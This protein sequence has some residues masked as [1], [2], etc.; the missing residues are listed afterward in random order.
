MKNF[1]HFKYYFYIK[2]QFN[3]TIKHNDGI[4]WTD[5]ENGNKCTY[6]LLEWHVATRFYFHYIVP[7]GYDFLLF[8]S[9]KMQHPIDNELNKILRICKIYE[10]ESRELFDETCY[11]LKLKVHENI[12][13]KVIPCNPYTLKIF[14]SE[15]DFIRNSIE[16]FVIH[17]SAIIA[18]VMYEADVFASYKYLNIYYDAALK[19]IRQLSFSSI[20]ISQIMCQIK[21]K[22]DVYCEQLKI[23]DNIMPDENKISDNGK[24][25]LSWKYVTFTNGY[26]YLYHP[27]HPNSSH[28]FK[29]KMKDSIGA[30]NSIQ[31]YFINRLSPISVQAKNGQITKV[32]NIED[33]E[34]CIQKLVQ[35]Y[36][37]RNKVVTPK[38]KAKGEIKKMTQEQITNHIHT[39]KSKYLDWLCS[40]QLSNYKIYYCLEVRSNANQQEKDEDAFIF[41]IKETPQTLILIYENSL[42]SRSS[43]IFKIKKYKYL[44]VI[45]DIHHFFSSNAVNKRELIIQGNISDVPLF[46]RNTYWRIMHTNFKSW[47]SKVEGTYNPFIV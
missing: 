2:E 12:T 41:T 38:A 21:H 31:S 36:K 9:K 22:V 30:F 39:Y 13:K 37:N 25:K 33:V 43:I 5:Y 32:L 3:L 24:F 17:T 26:I 28:P 29:Y 10:N 11:R 7:F 23:K 47:K 1:D 45:Q 15:Y 20:Q 19:A 27:L 35:K 40:K 34:F 44:D 16:D 4:S 6:T 14:I 8:Q 46:T 18:H 42:E